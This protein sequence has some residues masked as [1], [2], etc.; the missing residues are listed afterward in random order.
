MLGVD[1]KYFW[2]AFE[3]GVVHTHKAFHLRIHGVFIGNQS[4]HAFCQIFCRFYIGHACAQH[5]LD[6][7]N[8]GIGW[9]AVFC[10]IFVIIGIFAISRFNAGKVNI[11]AR[12]RSECLAF[13]VI[14]ISQ[15]EIIDRI[16]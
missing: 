3:I 7:G 8:G 16:R 1:F 15:P 14:C 9:L 2:G 12:N 5:I 6:L 11:T 4:G 10:R 13:I